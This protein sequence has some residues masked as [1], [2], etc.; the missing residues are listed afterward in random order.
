MAETTNL[1]AIGQFSSLTR[2]SVRMLRHYDTHGVLVPAHVDEWTG[3]RLYA[4]SQLR[5]ASDIRNLRDVGFGVS[6]IAAV[7]AS[8]GTPAWGNA[9]RLQCDTLADELR[10]AQTRVAL[11]ERMLNE[12]ET[13]MNITVER[14]TEPA[15]SIVALRGV[16]PTY[17]DEGVLWQ[18]MGPLL[19]E[20]GV[21]PIGPSGVIEHDDEYVEQDVDL[22]IYLPVAAGTHAVAPLE[23]LELPERECLMARVIGPYDQIATAHDLIRER[24]VREGLTLHTLKG[25]AGRTFNRYLTTPDRVRPEELVTEVC[26]PIG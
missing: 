24:A 5:D 2:I 26:V 22:S 13:T 19:R 23:I 16:V 21:Q 4:P 8:R 7:L 15:M 1:I 10:A 11:I 6:A 12:G 14:F 3:H 17:R 25:L 18:R 20:Q 9:L